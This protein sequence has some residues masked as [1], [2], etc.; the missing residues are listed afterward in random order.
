MRRSAR[1]GCRQEPGAGRCWRPARAD[2]PPEFFAPRPGSKPKP[3]R[4]SLSSCADKARTSPKPFAPTGAKPIRRAWRVRRGRYVGHSQCVRRVRCGQRVRRSRRVRRGR[5]GRGRPSIVR[6]V[7][8]GRPNGE[9]PLG[10]P[11]RACGSPDARIMS[12]RIVGRDREV[13]RRRTGSVSTAWPSGRAPR[14]AVTMRPSPQLTGARESGA[15]FGGRPWRVR[16]GALWFIPPLLPN[17]SCPQK[18]PRPPSAA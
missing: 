8:G 2:L 7:P 13:R 4:A 11:H 10:N 5:T 1:P 6:R 15:P 16:G 9:G 14:G 18:K 12:R 17:R 3:S